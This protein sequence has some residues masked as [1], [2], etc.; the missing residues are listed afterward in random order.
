ML[1]LPSS[2]ILGAGMAGL[3]AARE[4]TRHGWDVMV[5]DKGRGVGGRMATRRIE[6]A[7]VDHGAPYFS[8]KTPEFR[9]VADQLMAEGILTEWYPDKPD[10]HVADVL[11]G[12]SD[13]RR[14]IGIKG[15]NTVAKALANG[16]M[17]KTSE[18]VTKISVD[19][20]G[21]LAETEAGNAYPAESL[22]IT[23]PAPQALT[24]VQDSSL[25][26]SPTVVSA[27]SAILYQPCLVVLV[28][29][30][31]PSQIPSPGAVHYETGDVAWVVD[32]Q[33]K[34]ISPEQPSV[35]IQASPGFSQKHFDDDLTVVGRQLTE[36]MREWIPAEAVETIQVHRWRYSLA[37]ERYPESFLVAQTDLPLLFGG[38]GFG[39]GN[40]EGAF[41]SGL[42]MAEYL[43]NR[44]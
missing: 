38:D 19:G 27:L 10:R 26:L 1:I 41:L 28:V 39:T 12:D 7:K 30:R 8:V 24:L 44:P 23:I 15:M 22:L 11:S 9:Q 33:Q 35:L 31:Q 5:L 3:T 25:E 43:I 42:R 18:R 16:L 20:S 34:G 14:Y 36:Q 37:D 29:M 32:N 17:V 4:L 40:V 13:D 2:L 6:L 21:W